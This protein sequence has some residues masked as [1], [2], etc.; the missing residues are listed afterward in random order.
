MSRIRVLVRAIGALIVLAATFVPAVLAAPAFAHATLISSSPT[1]GQHL[2]SLPTEVRFEF[3]QEMSAPAYVIVTA[4]DG[5][6][7]TRGD[8]QVDGPVVSQAISDGPDGAYTMAYRAVSADGH[9]ITGEIAFTVGT[10][11]TPSPS[12]TG[13]SATSPGSSAPT[14]G[15]TTSGPDSDQDGFVTR[16]AVEI[17]IGAGLFGGALVLFVLSRRT[18]S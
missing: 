4:P 2:A 1:E 16:H 3:N 12:G 10:S 17:L 8:P 18:A 11:P 13:T 7:V 6:S 5:T 14:P 15:T 9:P